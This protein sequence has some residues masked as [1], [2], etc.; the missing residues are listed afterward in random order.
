MYWQE[1]CRRR[2]TR[3]LRLGAG[4]AL[5]AALGVIG[6][7]SARGDEGADN[8]VDVFSNLEAELR[9]TGMTFVA[10]R[11]DVNE[12]VLRAR[13]AFFVPDTNLAKLEN[14]RVT[15]TDEEERSSFE[16]SC[17]HGELDVETNDFL[18]EGNV[19]G[20]TG[21]G[22]RY[23]A[24]WVRYNHKQALL[25]TDAPVTM[26]DDTGTFR[27]DGFRYHVKQQRFR[28]LGNVSL[29]QTP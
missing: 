18:A 15:A 29:V 25:Y 4:L 2:Q 19:N 17:M 20:T 23:T 21:D 14:V 22:R 3:V 10:S 11:E 28:L 5:V 1:D 8:P 16:V 26:E 13:R 7:A 6:P 27:G 24:S 9:V 12:F